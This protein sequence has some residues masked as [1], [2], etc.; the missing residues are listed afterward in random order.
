MVSRPTGTGADEIRDALGAGG[1]TG[2]GVGGVGDALGGGGID[3]GG[4]ASLTR[5]SSQP[6]GSRRARISTDAIHQ[7]RTSIIDSSLP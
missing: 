5:V 2:D 1:G 7:R 4:A 6:P 3:T